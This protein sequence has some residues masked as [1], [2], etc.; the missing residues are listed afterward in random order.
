MSKVKV[1]LNSAGV[2]A[3]LKSG[4]VMAVL[5]GKAEALAASAGPGYG[6]NTCVGKN[7]ANAEVR[8]ETYEARKDAM[9]NQTLTRMLS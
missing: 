2:R 1:K 6:V 7:R 9:Q 4:D 3:M 5:Q 8:A